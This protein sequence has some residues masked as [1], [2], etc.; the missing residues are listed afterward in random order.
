[1]SFSPL[2]VHRFFSQCSLIAISFPH[3]SRSNL[4]VTPV[5]CFVVLIHG[6]KRLWCSFVRTSWTSTTILKSGSVKMT[7]LFLNFIVVTTTPRDDD[8]RSQAHVET[9]SVHSRL[10]WH[11]YM[12]EPGANWAMKHSA[13]WPR[14]LRFGAYLIFIPTINPLQNYNVRARGKQLTAALS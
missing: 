8:V 7:C 4:F 6:T 13:Y 9:W 10:W 12:S 5:W 3:D 1:M 2:E 11:L 14:I